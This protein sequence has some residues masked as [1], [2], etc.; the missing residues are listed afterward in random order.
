MATA[1]VPFLNACE[2]SWRAGSRKW[3]LRAVTRSVRPA[4]GFFPRSPVPPLAT[5]K[6]E[7]RFGCIFPS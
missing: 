7:P 1:K 4:L 5:P 3:S 6:A 2:V